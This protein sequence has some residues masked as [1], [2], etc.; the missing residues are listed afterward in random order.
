M[1]RIAILLASALA[2]SAQDWASRRGLTASEYSAVEKEYSSKGLRPVCISGYSQG[3]EERYGA[4]FVQDA[5]GWRARIGM[6]SAEYQ[7][8]FDTSRRLGFRLAWVSAHNH[9]NQ[10]RY[11]AIWVRGAGPDIAA[12]HGLSAAEYQQTVNTHAGQ[13]FRP[14]HVSV[15]VESGQPRFA[16]IFE[17]SSTPDTVA[18]HGMTPAEY[19][20]AVGE[21]TKQGFRMRAVAGYRPGNEDLFAAIWEKTAGRPWSARHAIPISWQQS[22]FDNHVYQAYRPTYISIYNS[23]NTARV[24]SVWENR[25]FRASELS[26]IA[27]RANRFRNTFQA[28]GIAFAITKDG[29]LVYAAGSG[30]VDPATSEEASPTHLFR[31]GSV[32]KPITAVAI[33]RLA[34]M[35]RLSL[36][37]RVFGRGG[38]LGFRVMPFNRNLEEITVRHLLQHVSGFSN[39]PNDPTFREPQR[40]ARDLISWVLTQ[41]ER[42]VTRQPGTLY[43]YNNLGYFILGEIVAA[44]SGTSYANFVMQNVMAPAGAQAVRPGRDAASERQ[45]REVVYVGDGAYNIQVERGLPAGGWIASPVDLMRF[46]VRVD[47]EPNPPDI[48][49]ADTYT[50]MTTRSGVRNANNNLVNY[51]MG[52]ITNPQGHNGAMAGTIAILSKADNGFAFVAMANT[53]PSADGFATNL[54]TAMR[55]IIALVSSW[56]DHDLF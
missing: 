9:Q 34:E 30:T 21:L 43:D 1:Y 25:A 56:P 53:R 13:G 37:D 36:D 46:F 31:I 42:A 48:I 17:K 19:Q 4:L 45:P 33:L 55:D 35:G 14:V 47:G 12:H 39:T 28:P 52:W 16:A 29:R 26:A 8:Q 27:D 49:R 2:L 6:T 54:A 3:A 5:A 41:P 40:D 15:H 10:V 24:N 51:G 18:R 20:A 7:T 44:R 38:I 11:A 32:A 22:V 50:A 23:A